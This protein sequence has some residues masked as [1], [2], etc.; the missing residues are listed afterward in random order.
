MIVCDHYLMTCDDVFMINIWCY[1]M[2]FMNVL[3]DDV[4]DY[5]DMWIWLW[6]F[7]IVMTYIANMNWW[8]T[9]YLNIIVE[10]YGA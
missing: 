7:M 5:D 8:L 2:T 3:I 9:M 1:L 10:L 6:L 4:Y